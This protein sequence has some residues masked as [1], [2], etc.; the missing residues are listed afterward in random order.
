MVQNLSAAAVRHAVRVVTEG[1]AERKGIRVTQSGSQAFVTYNEKT[2]A[3]ERI[4]V[5]AIPDNATP[6]FLDAIRGFIM[7]EV[8]HVHET[9][10]EVLNKYLRSLAVD[11]DKMT[12]EEQHRAQSAHGFCNLLEDARIEWKIQAYYAGAARQLN[13][14]GRFVLSRFSDKKLDEALANGDKNLAQSVV[15][16]PAIRALVGIS[17][18][19]SGQKVY[20]EW[21]DTDNRWQYFDYFTDKVDQSLIDEMARVETTEDVVAITERIMDVIYEAPE[22]SSM[23]AAPSAGATKT[24]N[25]SGGGMGGNEAGATGGEPDYDTSA[26]EGR[27]E[28]ESEGNRKDADAEL[29]FTKPSPLATTDFDEAAA[30]E[31]GALAEELQ[32]ASD[33]TPYTTDND[34]LGVHQVSS[35]Y[36]PKKLTEIDDTMRTMTSIIQ[37][38]LDRV[39]YAESRVRLLPG[40]RNGKIHSAALARLR[41]KDTRVFRKPMSKTRSDKLAVALVVDC[42][43]SMGHS[44]KIETA[45][46]AAMAMGTALD[47]LNIRFEI[48]GFT[49]SD[50]SHEVREEISDAAKTHRDQFQRYFPLHN[51]IFKTMD[52]RFLTGPRMRLADVLCGGVELNT[53]VDGESIQIV[54]QRLLNLNNVDRRV[55]IVLSDGYPSGDMYSQG[56]AHHLK[57]SVER[58]INSGVETIGIGIQSSAVSEFYPKY[59]VLNHIDDLPKEVISQVAELLV[60]TGI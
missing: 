34:F 24:A 16:M 58:C 32:S 13:D 19:N 44:N 45:I 51:P 43:G 39:M 55:M 57:S 20:L 6:V 49:T 46:V 59:A 11:P 12:A 37:Q 41:V 3:P 31:L 38:K 21:M 4:N 35:R 33:Y 14:V 29:D 47:K 8:A 7:H 2:K 40:Q 60:P 54:A 50:A 27:E 10:F 15:T 9:D 48:S 26:N 42:S 56:E 18:K 25:G 36:K 28:G 53:N 30:E 23:S 5:P 52:E 1:L 17:R 22:F